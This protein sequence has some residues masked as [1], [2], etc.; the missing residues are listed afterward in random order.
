MLEAEAEMLQKQLIKD[1]GLAPP[2][3]R[4]T[5]RPMVAAA[6]RPALGDPPALVSFSHSSR[7][8]SPSVPLLEPFPRLIDDDFAKEAASREKI[9]EKKKLIQREKRRLKREKEQLK[10]DQVRMSTEL[11][12]KKKEEKEGKQK[13]KGK[14]EEVR[15]LTLWLSLVSSVFYRSK[16]T[17]CPKWKEKNCVAASAPEIR[18]RWKRSHLAPF[19]WIPIPPN[20]S[21]SIPK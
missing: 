20:W 7:S 12:K 3:F 17:H 1:S 18:R 9:N 8:S 11:K 2:Q 13:K 16:P 5:T 21:P 6:P 15:K 4:E 14:S 10:K 19:G